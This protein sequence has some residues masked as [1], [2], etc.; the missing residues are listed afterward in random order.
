MLSRIKKGFFNAVKL[1]RRLSNRRRARLSQR[2]AC[3]I[4]FTPSEARN[5]SHTAEG[6]L[7]GL[8]VSAHIVIP[9]AM[10]AIRIAQL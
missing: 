2:E 4:Y 7:P 3:L 8:T 6:L 9:P 1:V 5:L 10:Q